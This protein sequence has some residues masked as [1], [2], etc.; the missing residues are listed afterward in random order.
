MVD[1]FEQFFSRSKAIAFLLDYRRKYP[2]QTF[3][4]NLR[5][6]FDRLDRCWKVTGHRFA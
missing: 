6:G 3:G 5:I 2:G 1:I 4:T